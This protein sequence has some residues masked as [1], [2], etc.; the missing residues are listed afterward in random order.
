MVRGID[1]MT[2]KAAGLR[3]SGDALRLPLAPHAQSIRIHV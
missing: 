3:L 2:G 1:E